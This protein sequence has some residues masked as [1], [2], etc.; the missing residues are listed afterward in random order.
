MRHGQNKDG[1]ERIFRL[2]NVVSILKK[3]TLE[4]PTNMFLKKDSNVCHSAVSFGFNDLSRTSSN[5][6]VFACSY[7][8]ISAM[9]S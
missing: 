2:L 3:N 1:T 4:N 8:R 5:A 6:V 9:L 7:S